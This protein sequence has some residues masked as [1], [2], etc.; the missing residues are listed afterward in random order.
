MKRISFFKSAIM[1]LATV[2]VV[3]CDSKDEEGPAL[4]TDAAI[5]SFALDLTA[6]NE[7]EDQTIKDA[8]K[9][10]I[11]GEE[12]QVNLPF[13]LD[14]IVMKKFLS[15]NAPTIGVSAGATVS[16]ASG[17]AQKFNSPTS[18]TYIV[19]AEDGISKTPYKVRFFESAQ[20]GYGVMEEYWRKAGLAF[21]DPFTNNNEKS[22]ALTPNQIILQSG[23]LYDNVALKLI[24]LSL[25]DGSEQGYVNLA[26]DAEN[27]ITSVRCLAG[28]KKGGF[29]A[30]NLAVEGEDFKVWAWENAEAAPRE[31][32]KWNVENLTLVGTL[33]ADWAKMFVGRRI[34]IVGD[35]KTT[36]YIYAYACYTLDILRWEVK[37]GTV[38]NHAPEFIKYNPGGTMTRFENWATICALNPTAETDFFVNA[39]NAGSE[40]TLIDG[41]TKAAKMSAGV[42]AT[43]KGSCSYLEFNGA[44][45]YIPLNVEAYATPH[46]VNARLYDYTNINT[47]E[48]MNNAEWLNPQ[49][50]AIAQSGTLTNG[51]ATG[52]IDAVLSADGE[53]FTVVAMGTGCGIVVHK[54]SKKKEL[55]FIA[56]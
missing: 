35:L 43:P 53:T 23:G 26:L 17:V 9:V 52:C 2:C 8:V 33:P 15:S 45:Y 46:N 7:L 11:V 44:K 25:L 31:L 14:S 1:L 21:S 47:S 3:S 37:N 40:V 50:A 12:I 36:A 4:K 22:F 49:P 27:S 20:T 28:D 42:M 51:D 38:V 34:S 29:I 13:G 5:T 55:T 54:F 48:E 39:A 18:V 19:T 32:I 30:C 24:K 56:Q 16:P 10:E 6:L 41:K